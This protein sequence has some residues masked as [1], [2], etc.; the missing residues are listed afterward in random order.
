MEGFFE[1]GSHI[2]SLF[3]F[4]PSSPA[5]LLH[6]VPNL[7]DNRT[8][9]PT[10]SRCDSMARPSKRARLHTPADGEVEPEQK[11][12]CDLL[13]DE[14]TIISTWRIRK[15]RPFEVSFDLFTP[16]GL[17]DRRRGYYIHQWHLT[18]PR[19][20]GPRRWQLHDAARSSYGLE[21]L[22]CSSAGR[23]IV[24]KTRECCVFHFLGGRGVPVLEKYW[25]EFRDSWTHPSSSPERVVFL[26]RYSSI[27]ISFSYSFILHWH[28][29]SD[30]TWYWTNGC[31]LL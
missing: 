10:F 25:E 6:C 5:L 2:S 29:T 13:K 28:Q 8:M 7:L 31:K 27:S 23:I 9:E 3:I 24:P 21:I 19:N 14:N 16:C 22:R 26:K 20:T 1:R 4:F 17:V 11:L 12:Y 15:I 30:V 18:R